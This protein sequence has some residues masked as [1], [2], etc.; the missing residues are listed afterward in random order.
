[1]L[2]QLSKP[3]IMDL[4]QNR[5]FTDLKEVLIDWTPIDIADLFLHYRKTNKQYFSSPS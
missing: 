3:E 1:M 4:I 5:Q 2:S